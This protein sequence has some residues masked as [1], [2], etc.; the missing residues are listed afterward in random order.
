MPAIQSLPPS[1]SSSSALHVLPAPLVANA[2]A[3][4]NEMNPLLTY[5]LQTLISYSIPAVFTVLVFGFTAR[6]FRG[7]KDDDDDALRIGSNN[8]VALLYDD[9]YGDQDQD[10]RKRNTFPNPFGGSR[11]DGKALPKNVGV[12][13]HQYLQVTHLNRKYDSFRYSLTA[14]TDSKAAAAAQFRRAS[15]ERAWSKAIPAAANQAVQTLEQAFLK[16]AA[17]LARNAEA[18]QASVQLATINEGMKKMGLTSV[19]QLDPEAAAPNQTST[20]GGSG[21]RGPPASRPAQLE[22]LGRLHAKRASLEADFVRDVLAAVGPD[23]AAAVRTAVLGN[24]GGVLTDGT[25]RPLTRLLAGGS[26]DGQ[27]AAS[28]ASRKRVFVTRF[29][30]DATASQVAN[31]REE[32]T[33]IV[34]SCR[35][36]TA[37]PAGG[38][39]DDEVL[40]VLQ[41]GGGTVTGYGLAAAQLL[42]LKQAG[43]HLTVAVEQVAASGGYMM[44]CIADRIVASPFAVLGSIGVISDIPNVYERL[45]EEGI[46]FQTVT[47]GK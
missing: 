35:A 29:P 22:A 45:K 11:R 30:G 47:A 46:E 9:L 4:A 36:A 32:V 27:G 2:A 18:L 19:Y 20:T 17:A 12:P 15:W 14:A 5:F 40:L 44:A 13:A 6:L 25:V 31:L 7:K 37:A 21:G 28:S 16:E 26:G 33:A 42:R 34:Q 8:P 39:N 23:H 24:S 41:T 43:L 3:G 10:P 38:G 1:S